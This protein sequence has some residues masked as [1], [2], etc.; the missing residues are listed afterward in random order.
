MHLLYLRDESSK[1]T[2]YHVEE[3]SQG[4]VNLL[5][6][7]LNATKTLLELLLNDLTSIVILDLTQHDLLR[8]DIIHMLWLQLDVIVGAPLVDNIDMV[9]L[10]LHDLLLDL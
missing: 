2:L 1:V 6:L 7:D 3:V 10:M 9:S 8:I 4:V 5:H